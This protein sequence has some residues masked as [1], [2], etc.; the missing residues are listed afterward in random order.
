[1]IFKILKTF[2]PCSA[3]KNRRWNDDDD[4][5]AINRTLINLNIFYLQLDTWDF[6]LNTRL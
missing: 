1:L 3:W 5:S 4:E 6:T 2:E